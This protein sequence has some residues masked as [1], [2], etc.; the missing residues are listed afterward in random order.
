MK[1][2]WHLKL[3][4]RFSFLPVLL[5]CFFLAR[6]WLIQELSQISTPYPPN[7]LLPKPRVELLPDPRFSQNLSVYFNEINFN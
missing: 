2:R 3:P 1:K 7:A 4:L 6:E 5:L